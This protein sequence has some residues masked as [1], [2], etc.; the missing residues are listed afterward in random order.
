M[1]F[2]FAPS[3]KYNI[4]CEH[5]VYNYQKTKECICDY[6][7]FRTLDSQ[8]STELIFTKTSRHE[9]KANGNVKKNTHYTFDTK[10]AQIQ[11]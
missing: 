10:K 1:K 11:L 7:L 5:A 9:R 4:L 6:F 3:I 2:L 8:Y